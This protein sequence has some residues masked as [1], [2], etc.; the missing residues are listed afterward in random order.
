MEKK[1]KMVSV[2][3]ESPS[4]YFCTHTR[5]HFI[6]GKYNPVTHGEAWCCFR[7][8]DACWN[9]RDTET[10]DFFSLSFRLTHVC[11]INEPKTLQKRDYRDKRNKKDS[12]GVI[13]DTIKNKS[14]SQPMDKDD[15]W[16]LHKVVLMN[17]L[18]LLL[19]KPRPTA[20]TA[21]PCWLTS[22]SLYFLQQQQHMAHRGPIDFRRNAPF[23]PDH[24]PTCR[25]IRVI[26]GCC[27]GLIIQRCHLP[28]NY[29]IR[30]LLWLG[31]C[32]CCLLKSAPLLFE[33]DR[34]AQTIVIPCR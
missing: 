16:S 26:G 31:S 19:L 4:L 11:C 24:L 21:S 17:Q 22:G 7:R 2:I 28:I 15:K 12:Q 9:T 20:Q 3:A 29:S 25:L 34:R 30:S 23:L 10:A 5:V 6:P 32:Y 8:S 33:E 13:L 27:D 18:F 14:M 1:Q